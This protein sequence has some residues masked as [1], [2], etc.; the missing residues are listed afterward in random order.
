MIMIPEPPPA[1]ET[2][3]AIVADL[4]HRAVVAD[5]WRTVKARITLAGIVP[6]CYVRS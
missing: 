6:S 5:G 3:T 1:P 4:A 2:A